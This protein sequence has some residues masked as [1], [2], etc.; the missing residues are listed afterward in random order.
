MDAGEYEQSIKYCLDNLDKSIHNW[1]TAR[2][3]LDRFSRKIA[4][5]DEKYQNKKILIV[6]HGFTINLYFAKLLGVLNEVY[7][8]FNTNDYCDWGI[9]KNGKVL[10][11]I[12][13]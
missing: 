2:H 7:Q 3:A 9:I 10:K 13:N 5:I 12:V 6:G 1:E 4:E 8:R 11:D